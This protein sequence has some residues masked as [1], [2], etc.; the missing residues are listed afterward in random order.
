MDYSSIDRKYQYVAISIKKHFVVFFN[1]INTYSAVVSKD[2]LNVMRLMSVKREE[3]D[4]IDI[5]GLAY[6][7]HFAMRKLISQN[8]SIITNG[9]IYKHRNLLD[10]ILRKPT[11][12]YLDGY[13][14]IEGDWTPVSYS[15]CITSD[16][17]VKTID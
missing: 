17:V 8:E 14:F 16:W 3:A 7:K 6:R 10:W 2:D 9:V 12:T 1:N 15:I 13:Y 11:K 5:S 4:I